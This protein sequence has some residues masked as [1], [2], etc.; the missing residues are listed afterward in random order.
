M[1]CKCGRPHYQHA[2]YHRDQIAGM[3]E[4]GIVKTM[5]AGRPDGSHYMVTIYTMGEPKDPHTAESLLEISQ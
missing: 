4:Q 5:C 1:T 3:W 2:W